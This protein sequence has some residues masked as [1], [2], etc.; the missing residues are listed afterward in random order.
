[1]PEESDTR[2][3]EQRHS[4]HHLKVVQEAS[5]RQ[6]CSRVP[7]DG[8]AVQ[9]QGSNEA[10]VRVAVL[11]S[12]GSNLQHG[13]DD[14]DEN[15]LGLFLEAKL[16]SGITDCGWT[17]TTRSPPCRSGLLQRLRPQIQARH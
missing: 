14:R 4:I 2:K 3:L 6:H 11:D 16:L 15:N 8:R 12:K 10:L 9:Q 7:H 1:M 13:S 5:D 17:A